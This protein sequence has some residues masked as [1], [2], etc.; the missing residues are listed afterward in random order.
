[1]Q[2]VKAHELRQKDEKALV[3]ELTKFRVSFLVFIF[4]QKEL[5]QLRVSK[6]SAAPQVKLARIRVI[7]LFLIL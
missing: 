2:R 1:M 3:D 6:V 5:S 4:L 7:I